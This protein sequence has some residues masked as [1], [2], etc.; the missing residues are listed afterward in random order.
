MKI[1][2]H[3]SYHCRFPV[4]KSCTLLRSLVVDEINNEPV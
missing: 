4:A 2:N 3:N 1:F